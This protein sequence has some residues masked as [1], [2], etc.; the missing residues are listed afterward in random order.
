MNKNELKI[1]KLKTIKIKGNSC[2]QNFTIP[3]RSRVNKRTHKRTRHRLYRTKK[4]GRRIQQLER[5]R[6]SL[7][8]IHRDLR[9]RKKSF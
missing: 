2:Q 3:K 8:S 5:I 9:S 4:D 6:N 7:K 1:N